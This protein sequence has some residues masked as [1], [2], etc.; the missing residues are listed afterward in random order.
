MSADDR[1]SDQAVYKGD[2]VP[3]DVGGRFEG[4]DVILPR[5][6]IS[7]TANGGGTHHA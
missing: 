7:S 6:S 3:G 2:N 5:M 1:S 4:L